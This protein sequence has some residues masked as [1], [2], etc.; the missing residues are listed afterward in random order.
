MVSFISLNLLGGSHPTPVPRKL[1]LVMRQQMDGKNATVKPSRRFFH[2][3]YSHTYFNKVNRLHSVRNQFTMRQ[4]L[5]H[6]YPCL[7]LVV[8]R[9]VGFII[10]GQITFWLVTDSQEIHVDWLNNVKI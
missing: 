2:N 5:V 8:E 3:G 4:N 6:S 9:R 1:G 7:I 10:I